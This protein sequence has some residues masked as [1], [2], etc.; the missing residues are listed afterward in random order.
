M[1]LMFLKIEAQE[2]N[3]QYQGSSFFRFL[4]S[5][6]NKNEVVKFQFSDEVIS[7]KILK[8][9]VISS[10]GK[11]GEKILIEYSEKDFFV[12][13]RF[14]EIGPLISPNFTKGA[15]FWLGADGNR[16]GVMSVSGYSQDVTRCYY[17]TKNILTLGSPHNEFEGPQKICIANIT[18]SSN[19]INSVFNFQN[20]LHACSARRGL[21]P[22][23]ALDCVSE[24]NPYMTLKSM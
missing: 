20:T 23:N 9:T 11:G 4:Q 22:E 21:C 8:L 16:Y 19:Q 7:L 10:N 13:E 24:N 12:K 6:V 1:S 18:C 2:E 17:D 14:L 15:L 5:K 3:P